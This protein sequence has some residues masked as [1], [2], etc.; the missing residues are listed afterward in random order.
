MSVSIGQTSLKA[1]LVIAPLS[2]H[3]LSRTLPRNGTS[4]RMSSLSNTI[5]TFTHADGSVVNIAR[6]ITGRLVSLYTTVADK[7]KMI[8]TDGSVVTRIMSSTGIVMFVNT[9]SASNSRGAGGRGSQLSV[10]V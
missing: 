4:T 3:A 7:S 5:S 9:M 2:M 10:E 1:D 8:N 6:G